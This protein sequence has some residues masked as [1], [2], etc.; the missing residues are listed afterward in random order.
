SRTKRSTKLSH[1]PKFFR[2]RARTLAVKV[3]RSTKTLLPTAR[4]NGPLRHPPRHLPLLVLRSVDLPLL[5]QN[6]TSSH[7]CR[8]YPRRTACGN[9]HYCGPRCCLTGCLRR[10]H[11]EGARTKMPVQFEEYRPGDRTVPQRQRRRFLLEGRWHRQVVARNSQIEI[12]H[13]L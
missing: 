6:E 13:Q 2:G 1:S 7:T 8:V 12:Q 5:I 3:R 11:G 4:L 9:R 10:R